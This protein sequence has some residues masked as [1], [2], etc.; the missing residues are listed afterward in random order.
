MYSLTHHVLE[1]AKILADLSFLRC[2]TR[3]AVKLLCRKPTQIATHLYK[4]YFSLF[5]FE[6]SRLLLCAAVV[7]T[8]FSQKH[9]LDHLTV[10][11]RKNQ[12]RSNCGNAL[13]KKKTQ[14]WMIFIVLAQ[15]SLWLFLRNSFGDEGSGVLK[16]YWGRRGQ[17]VDG[18]IACPSWEITARRGG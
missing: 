18:V 10:T 1:K 13:K 11:E 14:K 5:Y 17:Q 15:P 6:T 7:G 3:G 4:V 16:R 2:L 8:F 12:E 9:L